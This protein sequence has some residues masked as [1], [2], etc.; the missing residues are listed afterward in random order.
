MVKLDNSQVGYFGLA[1]VWLLCLSLKQSLKVNMLFL[2]IGGGIV[3]GTW[4]ESYEIQRFVVGR[5]ICKIRYI[6][7]AKMKFLLFRLLKK[8]EYERKDL[9][10]LL[11]NSILNKKEKSHRILIVG[12]PGCGKTTAIERFVLTC[13]SKSAQEIWFWNADSCVS[14]FRSKWKRKFNRTCS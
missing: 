4:G 11:E 7:S 14:S 2:G 5:Q 10:E 13:C 8:N 6:T 1:L 9:V 3:I 12:E